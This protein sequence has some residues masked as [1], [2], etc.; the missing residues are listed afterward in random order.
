MRRALCSRAARVAAFV[1]V[2]ALAAVGSAARVTFFLVREAEG[3]AGAFEYRTLRLD[4]DRVSSS[5]LVGQ[6][7]QAAGA[8]DGWRLLEPGEI[9]LVPGSKLVVVGAQVSETKEE[10]KPAEPDK[11]KP[12]ESEKD[13]TLDT[14]TSGLQA[15]PPQ[16]ET[17]TKSDSGKITVST[18]I[19]S[20]K[21]EFASEPQGLAGTTEGKAVALHDVQAGV[22]Y[23]IQGTSAALK[24]TGAEKRKL[25]GAIS[26]LF[27]R[28]GK[29]TDIGVSTDALRFPLF[30]GDWSID[31]MAIF[32]DNEAATSANQTDSTVSLGQALTYRLV[33]GPKWDD[34][35][36][37]RSWIRGQ[38]AISFSVG[39][40]GFNVSKID[41]MKDFDSKPFFGVG[42]QLRF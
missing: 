32:S 39:L 3:I 27:I 9:R 13:K 31:T 14:Q 26:I 22:I 23:S 36:S 25:D 40:R 35:E 28:A 2:L 21:V 4:T 37:R 15:Q 6:L 7:R 30:A 10:K 42:L 16:T 5:D 24:V 17:K 12:K 20:Q 29:A 33:L 18:F 34:F 19:G 8:K 41:S 1:T 38:I 11:D